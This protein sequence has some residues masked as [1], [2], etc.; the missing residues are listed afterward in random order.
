M[1]DKLSISGSVPVRTI[2]SR[3]SSSTDSDLE[4]VIGASLIGVTLINTV[5]GVESAVPSL[6]RKVNASLPLKLE[7]G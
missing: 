7:A 1:K 3:L 5:A 6:T 2:G 4:I